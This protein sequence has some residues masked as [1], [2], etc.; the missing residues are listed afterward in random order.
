[1]CTSSALVQQV[2]SIQR[3]LLWKDLGLLQVER[4]AVPLL[5]CQG[6]AQLLKL[7][8]IA[9]ALN[10][11]TSHFAAQPFSPDQNQTND[12]LLYSASWVSGGSRKRK[13]PMAETPWSAQ[14]LTNTNI[15]K[16]V[17][18]WGTPAATAHTL[19]P[20]LGRSGVQPQIMQPLQ[21]VSAAEGD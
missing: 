21:Q 3:S 17:Y 10:T 14:D 8:S 2:C 4:Y 6:T 7:D 11:P 13:A 9:A 1:M 15:T 5:G 12:Y 19:L 16:T 18:I 20:N